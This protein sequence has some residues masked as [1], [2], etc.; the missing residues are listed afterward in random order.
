VDPGILSRLV[1]PSCG[2]ELELERFGTSNAASGPITDGALLCG[3]C[4]VWYPIA[5]GIPV[6]LM[7]PTAF[8]ERFA[9]EHAH[10]IEHLA[11]YTAP[12]RAPRR[13][14]ASVQETFTE[15]WACVTESDLSFTYSL[16]EQVHLV[17]D[18][19]LKWARDPGKPVQ[20]V[21][22]V[23]CGLGSESL[24]LR[25]VLGADVFAVDLN[26]ALLERPENRS[27]EG[28]HFIVASLFD[29][30]FRRSS[31]DLVYSNGVLHHTRS[32]EDAFAE[33]ATFVR[34]GASLFV[35]VYGRDDHLAIPGARGL[36]RRAALLA[37]RVLR[38]A[39]SRA[40]HGARRVFFQSASRA[41][42]P[43]LRR[44]TR[45]ESSWTLDDTDNYLRDRLSPRFAHRHS[46]NEVIAWFEDRGFE[47]VDVHSSRSYRELIGKRLW[48][49]GM[50]GVRKP[51][52]RLLE[53]DGPLREP[54]TVDVGRD[55]RR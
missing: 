48:G 37:E 50:T 40:P 16:E 10:R 13:E 38:P 14:E 42:H 22:E 1:C 27:G 34:P 53:H 25:E 35:W 51:V 20:T 12:R 39:L 18:V 49:V 11:G 2:A 26:L 8:Q 28:V 21:L 23:G 24:A 17:G 45:H 29:L 19:W 9:S 7:F 47:I 52:S 31:F 15:E 33:I 44:T 4:R 5:S 54:L 32:T 43:L 6:L 41:A 30:P 55:V 3:H 36:A 46:F